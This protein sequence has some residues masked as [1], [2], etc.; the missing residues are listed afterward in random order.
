MGAMLNRWFILPFLLTL[1]LCFAVADL[2]FDAI[3]DWQTLIAGLLALAGAGWTILYLQKQIEEN[4]NIADRQHRLAMRTINGPILRA[5]DE[6]SLKLQN[7]IERGERGGKM[8]LNR[9]SDYAYEL[10]TS[11]IYL[12]RL[13]TIEKFKQLRNE[14]RRELRKWHG[15][16]RAL[17]P[18]QRL[19]VL[20][21]EISRRLRDGEDVIAIAASMDSVAP[22][23][24]HS[25]HKDEGAS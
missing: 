6:L 24:A 19:S 3:K 13:E 14:A 22:H 17:E 15:M 7:M 10:L 20:I 11:D 21:D 5:L 2:G 18:V 8:M 1:V 4:K 9:N 12:A 16:R 23:T 25:A